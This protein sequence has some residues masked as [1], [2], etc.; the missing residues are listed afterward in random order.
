MFFFKNWRIIL[1]K[2]I[3]IKFLVMNSAFAI[4]TCESNPIFSLLV[5]VFAD[6]CSTYGTQT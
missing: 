6:I 2:K 5:T 4:E 1:M 3:A